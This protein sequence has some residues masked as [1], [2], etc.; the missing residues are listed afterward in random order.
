MD[1][2]AGQYAIYGLNDV[3]LNTDGRMQMRYNISIYFSF[4]IYRDSFRGLTNQSVNLHIARNPMFYLL[5][6]TESLNKFFYPI[7]AVN[8]TIICFYF[9]YFCVSNAANAML[10]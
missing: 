4:S 7:V 2:V 5:Y 10:F 1:R 3:I 6:Y 8:F 9:I